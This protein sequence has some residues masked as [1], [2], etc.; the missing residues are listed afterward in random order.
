L[1][2]NACT[3]LFVSRG[4]LGALAIRADGVIEVPAF[5]VE[6]I[7][8]TGAGDAF[9]AGCIWGLLDGCGDR[10]TLTRGNALGALTCRALGA[11]A[12]LP[13][14]AQALS[15]LERPPPTR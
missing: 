15:F 14:R 6:A 12:G 4:P 3:I 2:G 9:A 5:V 8:T 11:R 13:T 10:E 7:D 1:P